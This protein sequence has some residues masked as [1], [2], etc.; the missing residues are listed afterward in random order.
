MKS[1]G[2]LLKLKPCLILSISLSFSS[3]FL[4][5]LSLIFQRRREPV[6][7]TYFFMKERNYD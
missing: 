3:Y 6:M 5:N 7:V 4:Q 2:M 1:I